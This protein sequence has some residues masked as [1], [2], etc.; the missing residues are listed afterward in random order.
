M[1]TF[2]RYRPKDVFGRHV[3]DPADFGWTYDG[4]AQE[5][6]WY[7]ERYQIRRGID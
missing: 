4:L 1:E 7:T 6:R 3:Y 2:L 5:F